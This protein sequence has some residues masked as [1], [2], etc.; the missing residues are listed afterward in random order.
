MIWGPRGP[1]VAPEDPGEGERSVEEWCDE[2]E[3]ARKVA[4]KRKVRLL[5][6]PFGVPKEFWGEKGSLIWGP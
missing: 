5:G 4:E 6:T 1:E 3:T 2:P